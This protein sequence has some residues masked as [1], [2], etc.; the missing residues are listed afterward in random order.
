MVSVEP[1][2]DVRLTSEAFADVDGLP[3]ALRRTLFA[4]LFDEF[5]LRP[6]E[7][8]IPLLVEI[9]G[10]YSRRFGVFRV[11]YRVMEAHVLV[12]GV[13]V[14]GG[15]RDSGDRTPYRPAFTPE[16]LREAAERRDAFNRR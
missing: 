10:V 16:F 1:A 8:G 13:T 11:L 7:A 15:V 9:P 4:S 5:A 14:D 2:Y 3:P 6:R 12:I